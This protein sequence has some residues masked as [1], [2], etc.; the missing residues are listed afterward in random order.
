[1]GEDDRLARAGGQ[2]HRRAPDVRRDY[3]VDRLALV[4]AQ[5]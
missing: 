3:G 1:M 5:G 2:Y 4:R